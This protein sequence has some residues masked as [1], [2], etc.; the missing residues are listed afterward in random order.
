MSL[1][2]RRAERERRSEFVMCST[3]GS[4][5]AVRLVQ[6][7]K[8]PRRPS[9]PIAYSPTVAIPYKWPR[10]GGEYITAIPLLNEGEM[11]A[12][13]PR[14]CKTQS[15]RQP[16]SAERLCFPAAFATLDQDNMRRLARKQN[17][18]RE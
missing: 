14:S 12:S 18:L 3:D 1:F 7:A 10:I 9:S 6:Q 13:N 16:D 4:K 17:K 5:T 15:F 8:F 2:E 11:A